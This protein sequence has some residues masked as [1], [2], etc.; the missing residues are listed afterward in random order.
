LRNTIIKENK[1][2]KTITKMI[3]PAFALFA[4]ACVV[5]SPMARATDGV[6]NLSDPDLLRSAPT[7]ITFDVP[8]ARSTIP[9]AINPAG[10]ITGFWVDNVNRA[11]HGF[12]RD[13]DGTITTFDA[14][15]AGTGPRQ[16][17]LCFSIN[18]AGVI[19][20][21]YVDGNDVLHGFV[22]ATDGT[23]T[24]FDAPGAGTGPGQGTGVYYRD[25]IS[26]ADTITGYYIDAGTVYH[27]YVRTAGGTITTC[28][29]CPLPTGINQVGTNQGVTADSND[30]L[31]GYVRDPMRNIL[32]SIDVPNQGTLPESTN[33]QEVIT[34]SYYGANGVAHGFE[35]AR[36]GAISTFDVPGAGTGPGQG[37][38]SLANNSSGAIAGFY[39]DENFRGH[40]FLRTPGRH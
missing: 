29:T 6:L 31:H 8:G 18:L 35:R 30:A 33:A 14:P 9:F 19:A 15:G 17:T 26:P 1:H 3:Y 21:E 36:S 40:G 4:F 13:S 2:M 5:L 12:L 39:T 10:L 22:R 16:G 25:G 34:G 24:T 20:G 27:G 37:T 7:F 23:I 11:R 38:F 32:I 28:P